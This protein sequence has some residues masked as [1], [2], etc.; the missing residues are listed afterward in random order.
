MTKNGEVAL[1]RKGNESI[2]RRMEPLEDFVTPAADIFE[3]AEAFVLKID[4]PGVEKDSI[5]VQLEPEQLTV[6]GLIAQLYKESKSLVYS[7]IRKASFY[8]RFRIGSGIDPEN[9]RANFE[10]GVLTLTLPKNE[11]IRV[12]EIPIK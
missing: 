11:S 1:V 4:L 8:R 12:R 5:S 2:A 6:K 7:E 9:V 3:T 10:D